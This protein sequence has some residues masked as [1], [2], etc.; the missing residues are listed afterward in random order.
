[1]NTQKITPGL[2]NTLRSLAVGQLQMQTSRSSTL[3]AVAIGM[4]GI[5]LA[6]AAIV[7]GVQS[8]H[9]L[10]IASLAMISLSFGLA[11]RILLLEGAKRDGPLVVDVLSARALHDDSTLEAS[12]IENLATAMLADRRALVRKKQPIRRALALLALAIV[13][14]LVGAIH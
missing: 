9:H 6:T 12:V 5:D 1:M 4:M 10:W 14:E 7:I 2:A 3:D 11:I 13:L 8:A